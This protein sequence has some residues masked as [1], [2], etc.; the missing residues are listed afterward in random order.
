MWNFKEI[1]QSAVLTTKIVAYIV[2]ITLYLIG[3]EV[4]HL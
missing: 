1:G 3:M 2:N 4:L